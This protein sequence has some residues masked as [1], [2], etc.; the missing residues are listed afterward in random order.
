MQSYPPVN[1]MPISEDIQKSLSMYGQ[2]IG[3]LL[4]ENGI[5]TFGLTLTG[6][7]PL[8]VEIGVFFDVTIGSVLMAALSYRVQETQSTVMTDALRELVD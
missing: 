7:M 3:F 1:Y 8:L 6:G 2:I 4:M 5:F